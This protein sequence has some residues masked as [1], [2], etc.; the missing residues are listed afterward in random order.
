[1]SEV[2]CV[3]SIKYMLVSMSCLSFH[4]LFSLTVLFNQMCLQGVGKAIYYM[5]VKC[6]RVV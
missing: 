3:I 2:K 4:C 1:M 6:E 5:S